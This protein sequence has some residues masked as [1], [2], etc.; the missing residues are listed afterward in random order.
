[1]ARQILKYDH[2]K[3]L[4]RSCPIVLHFELIG[5]GSSTGR[6]PEPIRPTR[7]SRTQIAVLWRG[8]ASSVVPVKSDGAVVSLFRLAPREKACQGAEVRCN[9]GLRAAP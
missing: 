4:R 7:S 3:L 2:S 1:M 9:R 6:S 8:L 5:E